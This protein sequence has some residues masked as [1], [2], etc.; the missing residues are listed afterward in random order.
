M[1]DIWLPT[2]V[3]LLAGVLSTW[4]FVPQVVKIW[5]EGDTGAISLRTFALRAFGSALWTLYGFGIGSVP[6]MIFSALNFV[7]CATI[8]MLKLRDSRTPQPA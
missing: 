6:V 2:A 8:L 7:L 3:G 1:M 5:R 4:S